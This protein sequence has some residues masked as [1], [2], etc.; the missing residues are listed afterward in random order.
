MRLGP[1][2]VE[3]QALAINERGQ[4]IGWSDTASGLRAV[5]WEKGK[6]RDLGGRGT[7]AT[8]INERGQIVGSAYTK[9]GEQHAF[10]F[11]ENGK[12]R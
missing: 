2:D 7:Y 3:S 8:A 6:M 5:V 4:V 9:A 12:M 10:F 1:L 11:R